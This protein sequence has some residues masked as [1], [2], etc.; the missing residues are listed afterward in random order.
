VRLRPAVVAAALAAAVTVGGCGGSDEHDGAGPLEWKG[1]PLVV[2]P[3][4]LPHDRV[5][6]G[7]VHNTSSR[8]LHL[9]AARLRVRDAAGHSLD[10]T[11]GFTNTFGHGLF[12][13]FQQPARLPRA[14]LVR[15]GK[16][17]D[18]PPGASAPFYA[19]WRLA[20]NSREPVRV[21]YGAGSLEVPNKAR[22]GTP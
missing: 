13:A 4:T 12:G 6:I 17:V 18:I 7:R 22:S 3:R 20:A 5:V 21:D 2:R 10:S 8:T 1:R 19:A 16:I 14:E 11:A 15:L 9:V